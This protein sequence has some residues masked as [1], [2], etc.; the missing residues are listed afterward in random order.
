MK[1]NSRAVCLLLFIL[2]NSLLGH[3]DQK[4]TF[5]VI[6]A[7]NQLSDN[8]AQVVVCTRTGRMIISTLG[9]IN[10]FDGTSF[11]HIDTRSEYQYQL[12]LYKGNYHLY[13]DNKHHIWLKNGYSVTCVDL[14]DE[15]FVENVDSV[16]KNSLGCQEQVLDL[17][18]DSN[19]TMWLLTENGLYSVE[20]EKYYTVL[21]D[22]N[23][24]ELDVVGDSTLLTFYDNGDE[25]GQ[26]LRS[27][28]TIHRTRCY[29][30]QIASTYSNTGLIYRYKDGFFLIR[31]GDSSS[32]LLYFDLTTLQWQELKRLPYHMCGIA[33]QNN[34]EDVIYI[35]SSYGYWTYDVSKKEFQ[36][37]EELKMLSGQELLTDCNT[38]TF[39]KQGGM[40]I[41]TE[42][43]GLFYSRP[44][45]SWFTTYTRDKPEA[46]EYERLMQHL[47]QNI[48]EFN[49]Q[50]AN[51]L[52][53]DSRGWTW[54]GT[55]KGLHLYRTINSEPTIID[56]SKGLLNNVIHSIV[57]DKDH[58]I[59]VST[60]SGIS[61]VIFEKGR[62]L[63]V[64]SFNGDDNVPNESFINGKAL[65]LDDGTIIMQ[66]LD[67]VLKFHPKDFYVVNKRSPMM[68]HPKLIRLLVNGNFVVPKKEEN[69][70]VIIDRAISRAYEISLNAEQNSISLTFSALN[71]FRP[72]QTY[73]RVRVTGKGIQSNWKVYNYYNSIGIVDARGMLHLPLTGLQ[74]GDY[75]VEVQASL[76]PDVWDDKPYGWT[77]HVN[78]PWWRTTGVFV[79][80]L[81][82]L[83]IFLSINFYLYSRNMKMRARR[84]NEEGDIIRKVRTFVDR[85]DMYT[86]EQLRLTKEDVYGD[87]QGNRNQ[88][89]P[90]FIQLMITLMPYIQQH[91]NG[92]LSMSQM[93]QASNM[94]IT[95]LYTL[96]T[97]NLYKNPRD[98]IK[99]VRLQQAVELLRNTDRPIEDIA[100]EC[101]FASPNYFISSF[102][103][104]YK[105]TPKEYREDVK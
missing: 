87:I 98:L 30:W 102:F 9:N 6:N 84:I 103:H 12:P 42:K 54:I 69:G 90:E 17:F 55:N 81:F 62:E 33:R 95:D 16:I 14:I 75:M 36:H 48:T 44:L 26:D 89:S 67:H 70:N 82:L 15:Q 99:M 71:Y 8:S 32:I 60:S 88:M 43:R 77:I 5:K 91:R 13:F 45:G 100:R 29:D 22:R 35:P 65:C 92:D 3:A 19:N 83:F 53:S 94:D 68:P 49:G 1:L 21:R 78:Q 52:F 11:S 34:K 101:G 41:G 27:G 18:A 73:Y 76:F 57:E 93:S 39:D 56:K 28:C 23:L 59:W 58:N 38:M 63:F 64:N 105:M 20:H 10:F 40:W 104:Q 31:N 96:I 66:S 97:G 47:E 2:M 74:P 61:C 85:C 37:I 7:S 79:G 25:V 86:N 4:R 24:Q 80:L 51:C 46:L 50:P 72:I